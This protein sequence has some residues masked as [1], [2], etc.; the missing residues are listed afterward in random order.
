LTDHVEILLL[1]NN[2]PSGMLRDEQYLAGGKLIKTDLGEKI[3]PAISSSRIYGL[4]DWNENAIVSYLKT[5]VGADGNVSDPNFCPTGFYRNASDGDLMAI[6][7]YLR[8]V[9]G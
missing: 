5:G 8:T 4:G 6:A 1:F 3:A 2:S 9:P 7:R